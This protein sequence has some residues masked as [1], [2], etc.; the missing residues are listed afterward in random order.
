MSPHATAYDV[1]VVGGGHNGLVAAG[2][3]ARAGLSVLV[4]ERLDRVG[5]AIASTDTF[6]GQP[7]S[8]SRYAA[9]GAPL[10]VQLAADLDLDLLL[11]AQSHQP[12]PAVTSAK[13]SG[14]ASAATRPIIPAASSTA[15]CRASIAA[16]Q[17]RQRPRRI[18]QDRIGIRSSAPSTAPQL[19]QRD[20]PPDAL[21]P[22]GQ[23]IRTVAR[24]DP[25][26]S[27]STPPSKAA[28]QSGMDA[29]PSITRGA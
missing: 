23:R 21:S 26:T 22:F 7:L 17:V 18:T 6:S 29:N 28:S 4:L 12:S 16:P 11:R 15:R 25:I 9:L 2:Y 24:K 13:G 3:L 14:C 27:P 20:R 5:G 19:S 1:T 10:P 8:V